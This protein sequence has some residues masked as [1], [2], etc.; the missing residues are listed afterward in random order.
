MISK[1]YFQ[2]LAKIIFKEFIYLTYILICQI[3]E[4]NIKIA[5]GIQYI[6]NESG[7]NYIK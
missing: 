2:T 7:P 3:K 1:L 4:R 6:Q 5:N